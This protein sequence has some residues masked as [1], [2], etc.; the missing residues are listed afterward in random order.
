LFG[1]ENRVGGRFGTSVA[2][3]GDVDGDSV[4]DLAVG[5]PHGWVGGRATDVVSDGAVV[6]FSGAT[7]DA[8]VEWTAESQFDLATRFGASI[9]PLGDVDGDARPDFA[10]GASKHDPRASETQRGSVSVH[11][12]GTGALVFEVFGPEGGVGFFGSRVRSPGDANADGVDDLLVQ[13]SEGWTLLSGR[14]GSLLWH[15]DARD[16]HAAG[17]PWRIRRIEG[18][19]ERSFRL[20]RGE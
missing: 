1:L 14:D 2:N 3:V 13:G 6:L 7:G 20:V 17:R 4:P 19:G 5:A 11:S 10:V 18:R 15:R 9:V 12:G 8:L 16:T